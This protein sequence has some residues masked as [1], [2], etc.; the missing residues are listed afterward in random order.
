MAKAIFLTNATPFSSEMATRSPTGDLK[1]ATSRVICTIYGGEG[2]RRAA[3]EWGKDPEVPEVGHPV[4]KLGFPTHLVTSSRYP[5][6]WVNTPPKTI[7]S[8]VVTIK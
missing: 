1:I 5:V 2:P 8:S 4:W 3:G 6:S 7:I